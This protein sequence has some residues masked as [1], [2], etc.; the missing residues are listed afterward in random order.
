MKKILTLVL[1]AMFILSACS[2]QKTG[3]SLMGLKGP[4]GIGL[5]KLM[6]D[7]EEGKAANDYSFEIT[8]TPDEVVARLTKGEIDAAAIPANLASVLYNKTEGAV[9]VAAVNTL[10]VLYILDTTGQIQTIEDLRGKTI[11]CSG[12]GT[13]T[14]YVLNYILRQNGME[15]GTDVILEFKSEATELATLMGSGQIEICMLPEP[16]VTTVANQNPAVNVALSVTE[17]WN[18]VADTELITGVLVV[19]SEFLDKNKAAFDKFLTEYKASIEYMSTNLTEGAALTE[20]FGIIPNAK[21]A[22]KAIPRCNLKY[23][24]KEDM[25]TA[26]SAYLNTLFEADP[27]SVGGKVPGDD[28]YYLGK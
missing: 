23:M 4:T 15:P 20:K 3:M 10:G 11:F 17:E 6:N 13:V 22:E 19:R 12:L 27:K 8:G 1:A 24:D 9:K 16:Q 26:L 2:T 25:K 14:E 21:L 18:K 28:F 7:D 5:S